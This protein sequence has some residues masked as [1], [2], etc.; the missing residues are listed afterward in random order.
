MLFLCYLFRFVA[1]FLH[2]TSPPLHLP[3]PS[4]SLSPSCLGSSLSC[5]PLGSTSCHFFAADFLACAFCFTSTLSLPQL[6]FL[7]LPLSPVDCPFT[8]TFIHTQL[9]RLNWRWFNAFASFPYG[10]HSTARKRSQLWGWVCT[11]SLF[12]TPSHPLT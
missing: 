11:A 7:P 3:L 4:L 12:C 9:G 10:F 5:S 2:S 1:L 6:H 8:L